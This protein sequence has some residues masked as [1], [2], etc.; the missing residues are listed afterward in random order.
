MVAYAASTFVVLL[1]LSYTIHVTLVD[2]EEAARSDR[3]PGRTSQFIRVSLYSGSAL[4][5][6]LC[7]CRTV[8]TAVAAASVLAI[9]VAV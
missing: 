6:A 8:D 3:D 4:L 7:A 9:A 2:N 5:G 1:W